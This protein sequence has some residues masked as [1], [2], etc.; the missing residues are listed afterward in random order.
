MVRVPSAALSS[1]PLPSSWSLPARGSR[2]EFP[3]ATGSARTRDR[4]FS[5]VMGAFL[6]LL[7][8]V[9]ATS[10]HLS[11]TFRSHFFRL[12]PGSSSVSYRYVFFSVVI[13]LPRLYRRHI[14]TSRA[15]FVLRRY[16]WSTGF[17]LYRLGLFSVVNRYYV[18]RIRSYSSVFRRQRFS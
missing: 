9:S 5:G 4:F 14:S 2:G 7:S 8:S 10:F 6:L 15:S 18:V 3:R 1:G 16:L 11:G 17:V 13:Y 12:F